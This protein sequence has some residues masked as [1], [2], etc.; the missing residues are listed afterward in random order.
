MEKI[1]IDAG[2]LNGHDRKQDE[3]FDAIKAKIFKLWPDIKV[4]S[5]ELGRCLREITYKND[6]VELSFTV[7]SSD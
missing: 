7:D 1:K 2:C 4:E 5:K 3:L 6:K